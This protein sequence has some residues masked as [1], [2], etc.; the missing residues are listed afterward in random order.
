M[1]PS[2]CARAARPGGSSSAAPVSLRGRHPAAA[3]AVDANGSEGPPRMMCLRTKPARSPEGSCPRSAAL[4]ARA[5]RRAPRRSTRD[6][7]TQAGALA[8]ARG[9]ELHEAVENPPS[10]ARRDAVALSVTRIF[11]RRRVP[12]NAIADGPAGRRV[13]HGVL[14]QVEHAAGAAGPRRR[15]TESRRRRSTGSCTPRSAAST[16][17]ARRHSATTSSR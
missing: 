10:I 2:M 16:S 7:Q 3:I 4:P 15:G 6:R 11:T 9:I 5:C 12:T 13:L 1:F 14:Q 17:T 8:A